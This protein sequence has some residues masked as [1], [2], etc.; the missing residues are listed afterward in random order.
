MFYV[1]KNRH[2]GPV[3]TK[4][5]EHGTK[6]IENWQVCQCADGPMVQANVWLGS[7]P[8]ADATLSAGN[9][10]GKAGERQAA[11]PRAGKYLGPHGCAGAGS[12]CAQRLRALG[13]GGSNALGKL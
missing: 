2:P 12:L 13:K 9:D 3:V 5:L 11:V 6:R 1:C 4:P 8:A 10:S 7:G